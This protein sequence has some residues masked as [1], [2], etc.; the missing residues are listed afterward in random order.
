MPLAGSFHFPCI[1]LLG[2]WRRIHPVYRAGHRIPATHPARSSPS[3]LKHVQNGS[4]N[5]NKLSSDFQI[6]SYFLSQFLSLLLLISGPHHPSLKVMLWLLISLL[7]DPLPFNLKPSCPQNDLKCK[8]NH[9]TVCFI[10]HVYPVIQSNTN[11]D[12]AV[13]K[14][15]R[16]I[17]N[18]LYGEILLD[19]LR[20]PDP[21]SWK[22]LRRRDPFCCL[23]S[24]WLHCL[25]HWQFKGKR[26]IKFIFSPLPTFLLPRLAPWPWP[27]CK[28]TR[29]PEAV[30]I[31]H[32]ELLPL[33]LPLYLYPVKHYFVGFSS[34]F[35]NRFFLILLFLTYPPSFLI[36]Q[37]VEHSFFSAFMGI[38][39]GWKPW[40]PLE[41][42]LQLLSIYHRIIWENITH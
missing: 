18:W 35:N 2:Q 7:P 42:P 21:I 41:I 4:L 27:H 32:S 14:F 33:D 10:W 17:I 37:R 30:N 11:L 34:H 22:A 23:S 1:A 5:P 8:L 24:G 26:V 39:W 19:D 25:T 20:G 38:V 28:L 13:K 40:Q 31:Q 6:S 36:S 15:S 3:F 12:D 16:C 9:V 29:N